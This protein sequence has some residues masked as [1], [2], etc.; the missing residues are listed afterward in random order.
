MDVILSK[1][2]SSSTPSRIQR[3]DNRKLHLHLGAFFT[4]IHTFDNSAAT[5]E[6]GVGDLDK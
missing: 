3:R 1:T 5:K 4:G 2:D 6:R